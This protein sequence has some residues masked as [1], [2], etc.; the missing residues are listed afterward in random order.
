MSTEVTRTIHSRAS[1]HQ[2][3]DL[4]QTIFLAELFCPGGDLWIMSPWISDIPVIDNRAS[5][6]LHLEPSWGGRQVRL[7]EV[8]YQIMARG[9]KVHIVT[10]REDH[11]R[12]FIMTMEQ[13]RAQGN[14]PLYIKIVDEFHEKGILGRNYYLSGSM[15]F[16]YY[17]ITI[18]EEVLHYFT[19]PA[20]VAEKKLAVIE[21]WGS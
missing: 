18:N 9:T 10:R 7:S 8:L 4:L 12:A 21:R 15:N 6:F 3:V 16:T 1:S 2:V 20:L 11:N 14:L 13:L 17:G 5:Q 19:Q